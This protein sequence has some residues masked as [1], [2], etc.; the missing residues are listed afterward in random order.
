MRTSD[1]W[2]SN[3]KPAL[4]MEFPLPVCRDGGGKLHRSFGPQ[5]T[6]ASG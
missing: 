3:Q 4:L 5:R 6:R 2:L 1:F